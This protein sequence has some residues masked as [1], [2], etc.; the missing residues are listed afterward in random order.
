MDLYGKLKILTRTSIHHEKYDDS[1]PLKY[2][3]ELCNSCHGRDNMERR[4]SGNIGFKDSQ[5]IYGKKV[6]QFPNYE[7]LTKN[8][9]QEIQVICVEISV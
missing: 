1:N 4:W 6:A 2:T 5:Y 3:I 7:T 9:W 8:P